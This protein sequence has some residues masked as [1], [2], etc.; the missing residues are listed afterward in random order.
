MAK[1][2]DEESQRENTK[3]EEKKMIGKDDNIGLYIYI[4]PFTL[5]KYGF[6]FL[7]PFHFNCSRIV[8][9][10]RKKRSNVIVLIIHSL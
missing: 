1:A 4:L 5:Y 9:D 2:H 3:E 7:K 8:C 10:T 6:F